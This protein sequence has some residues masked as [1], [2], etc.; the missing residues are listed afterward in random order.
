MYFHSTLPSTVTMVSQR[1]VIVI[2]LL[3]QIHKKRN[4][5][6][7]NTILCNSDDS[8][9]TRIIPKRSTNRCGDNLFHIFVKATA[10]AM[11]VSA[12]DVASACVRQL[13]VIGNSKLVKRRQLL[14]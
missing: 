11:I 8:E 13:E 1:H 2:L 9:A 14:T 10:I 12:E 4:E 5:F 3:L 7:G 6:M